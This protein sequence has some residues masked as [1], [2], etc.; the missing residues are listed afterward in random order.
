MGYE[1]KVIIMDRTGKGCALELMRI[2]V[3]N[4]GCTKHN[5]KSFP[6]VFDTPIDFELFVKCDCCGECNNEYLRTDRYGKHCNYTT[7][8]NLIEWLTGAMEAD[9][10]LAGYRRAK[11][12][13]NTLKA[14]KESENDFDGM[15]AVHFG[16]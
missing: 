13:L 5:G 7:I 10:E 16:Y 3:C 8:D 12:L 2:D 11:M 4:M 14:L 9:A 1:S 15:V 6:E